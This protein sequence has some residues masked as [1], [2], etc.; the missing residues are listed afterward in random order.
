MPREKKKPGLP[1]GIVAGY[2]AYRRTVAICRCQ[3]L[4]FDMYNKILKDFHKDNCQLIP[5]V[6]VRTCVL[7]PVDSEY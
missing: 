6:G 4:A 2:P 7:R 1:F 3:Q 5:N